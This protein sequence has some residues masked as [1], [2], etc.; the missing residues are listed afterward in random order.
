MAAHTEHLCINL[1]SLQWQAGCGKAYSG[2]LLVTG[3]RQTAVAFSFNGGKDSTVLLHILRAAVALTAE[4]LH[5][6]EDSEAAVAL[7][8]RQQ[9]HAEAES[10]NAEAHSGA[11]ARPGL[12]PHGV[13]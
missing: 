11:K 12:V 6:G 2:F 5:G 3:H 9:S 7:A 8:A 10:S 13:C 1:L 4:P